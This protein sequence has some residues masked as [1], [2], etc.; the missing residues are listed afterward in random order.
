MASAD[1]VKQVEGYGLTMRTFCTGVPII[2]GCCSRISLE[3]YVLV[4]GNS[5]NCTFSWPFGRR[6]FRV[7]I[8]CRSRT[9][10]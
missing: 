10:N 8:L 2:A 3:A 6:S 5:P 9:A 4:S 7:C 1:F